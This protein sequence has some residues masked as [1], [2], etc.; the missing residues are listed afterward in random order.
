MGVPWAPSKFSALRLLVATLCGQFKRLF[1]FGFSA[2]CWTLLTTRNKFT[3]EQVFPNS[4][5][6]IIFKLS[7]FL[8]QRESLIREAGKAAVEVLNARVRVSTTSIS[9][10]DRARPS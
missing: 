9:G 2:M 8:Q 6:N 3:I 4:A 1:W 5:V 7:I 10:R